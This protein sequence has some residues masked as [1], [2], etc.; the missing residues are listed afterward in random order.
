MY[1]CVMPETENLVIYRNP[2][3]TSIAFGINPRNTTVETLKTLIRTL[4]D[5][6]RLDAQLFAL[7]ALSVRVYIIQP[8][9]FLAIGQMPEDLKTS[10][11]DQIVAAIRDTERV[12]V[13]QAARREPNP[14]SFF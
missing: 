8:D 7:N 6:T 4:V 10:R 2:E 3:G 13:R 12:I 5:N 1:N 11:I 14:N 9:G